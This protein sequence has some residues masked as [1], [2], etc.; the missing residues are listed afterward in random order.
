M[1]AAATVHTIRLQLER[2]EQLFNSLD[3]SPFIGRDL[4][5]TAESFISE[6]A[7]EFPHDGGFRLQVLLRSATDFAAAQHRAQDA[8]A[9]YYTARADAQRLRLK[10]LFR[11]GRMSLIIGLVFLVVCHLL[12]TALEQRFGADTLA[13]LLA[14]GLII[15]GWVAMWRP[16]EIFLYDWWPLRN[17]L[18]LML[19]LAAAKVEIIPTNAEVDQ[20]GAGQSIERHKRL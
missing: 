19:R 12:S 20:A 5:P 3:P 13:G 14:H 6:W 18:K 15:A 7:E 8:V 9:S 17:R 11:N 2:I 10:R 16:L 4:D 1:S